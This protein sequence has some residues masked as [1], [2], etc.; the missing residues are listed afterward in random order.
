MSAS[1]LGIFREQFFLNFQVYMSMYF[2]LLVLKKLSIHG[3]AVSLNRND[4]AGLKEAEVIA[5]R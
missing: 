2:P 4:M 3:E 1:V 5:L